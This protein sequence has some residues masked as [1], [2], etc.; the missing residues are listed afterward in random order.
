[1]FISSCERAEVASDKLRIY[2]K[3][4]HVDSAADGDEQVGGRTENFHFFFFLCEIYRDT[5]RDCV[6]D[7]LPEFFAPF[8]VEITKTSAAKTRAERTKVDG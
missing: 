6:P 4:S 2:A 1:M 7:E 3:G 8:R 5:E